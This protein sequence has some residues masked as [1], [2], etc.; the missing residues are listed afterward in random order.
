MKF[1]IR[2]KTPGNGNTR[3][4]GIHADDVITPLAQMMAKGTITAAEIQNTPMSWAS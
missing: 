3:G 4:T 1:K 2:I